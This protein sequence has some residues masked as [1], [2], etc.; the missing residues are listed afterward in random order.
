MFSK[1]CSKQHS[2]LLLCTLKKDLRLDVPTNEGISPSF[3]ED[4]DFGEYGDQHSLHLES[5]PPAVL[6]ETRDASPASAVQEG[7]GIKPLLVFEAV[8]LHNQLFF[9]PVFPQLYKP[10]QVPQLKPTWCRAWGRAVLTIQL[11]PSARFS[12]SLPVRELFHLSCSAR[13][14]GLRGNALE[15]SID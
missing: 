9:W 15:R 8:K 5:S 10:V 6:G 4:G 2:Y 11:I 12:A 14:A 1:L 7:Q 13:I 3:K